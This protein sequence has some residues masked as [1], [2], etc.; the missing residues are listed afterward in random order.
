MTADRGEP[1]EQIVGSSSQSVTHFPSFQRYRSVGRRIGVTSAARVAVALG[2][3]AAFSGGL[4]AQQPCTEDVMIVFDAS[5]SMAASSGEKSG[6]RR[7]D[8]VRG[9]LAHVLPQVSKRRHIG[10][11]TYGPG[12]RDACSN[13]SLELRPSEDAADK[14]MA[15]IDR[16]QPDGKTPLTT[17]VRRAAEVLDFRNRPVTIVLLTDGEET[18]GGS[19]CALAQALRDEGAQTTVH[20]I[21]YQITSAIGPGGSFESRCLADETGGIYAAT[22]TAEQVIDA[23]QTTLACPMVS[24]VAPELLNNEVLNRSTVHR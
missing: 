10:L 4:Q 5:R 11:I 24:D 12:R 14:I 13:I 16:L 23:L 1:F 15:R 22:D 8:A 19:P 3:L 17:S 6:L 7:I 21:S 2:A 9:A 20:V 18:C